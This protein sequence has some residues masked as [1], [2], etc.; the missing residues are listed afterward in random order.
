MYIKPDK[1]D[2]YEKE[3][4]RGGRERERERAY[5]LFKDLHKLVCIE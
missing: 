1:Q 3:R 4:G 2:A 5:F